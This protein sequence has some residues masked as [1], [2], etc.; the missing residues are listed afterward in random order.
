VT[1]GCRVREASCENGDREWARDGWSPRR[2]REKDGF[3]DGGGR[4]G[5]RKR[6]REK[7]R[8]AGRKR[9]MGKRRRA[10]GANENSAAFSRGNT[11][12]LFH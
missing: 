7:E 3:R 1:R 11:S 8:D 12:Y 6:D 10:A 4:E 5:E 2:K 9:Q